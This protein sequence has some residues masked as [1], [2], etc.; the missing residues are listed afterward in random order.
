MDGT[1]PRG[2][3]REDYDAPGFDPSKEPVPQLHYQPASLDKALR[4]EWP[5][6]LLLFFNL[7]F[8]AAAYF[9]FTRYDVR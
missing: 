7:V 8:F 5:D 4:R 1:A 9:S 2:A 3:W 6:I